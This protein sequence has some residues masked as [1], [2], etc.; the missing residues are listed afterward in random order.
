M[1]KARAVCLILAAVALA[2]CSGPIKMRNAR[3][4]EI[5]TCGP[6]VSTWDTAQRESQCIADFQRQGF[7]RMP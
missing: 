1:Q 2:G 3:S 6:F 5:A 4:G 7:E